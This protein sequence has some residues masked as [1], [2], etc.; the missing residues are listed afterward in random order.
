MGTNNGSEDF[1]DEP[2]TEMKIQK[3][4]E[5]FLHEALTSNK[6]RVAKLLV[7]DGPLRQSIIALRAG[8]TLAEH[9]SPPAASAFV[10]HGQVRISGQE[11]TILN[12][13]D[14]EALTHYRHAV[15]ALED[16]VFLLT[17]VTSVLGQDSHSKRREP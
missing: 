5:D 13:G 17:T 14:L 9:N 16:S 11:E 7:K 12:A 3:L 4:T 2:G 15:E 8:E 6:G 1:H 10:L